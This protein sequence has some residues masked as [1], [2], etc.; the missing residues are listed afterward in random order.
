MEFFTAFKITSS[1]L[2]AQRKKMDVITGNI[3]NASTTST[4]EGGP[5]KRKA[6]SF[7]ADPVEKGFDRELREAVNAVKV[8]QVVEDTD[9]FKKVFDPAH[10]DADADGF[11]TMPNVNLM[12]EM[13][14]L[15]TA[16]RAYEANAS[17]FDAVKSMALKA[18]EIGK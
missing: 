7:A 1:G 8:G 4:P 16:S 6:I 3:A 17:A 9:N 13:T 18:I 15:I 12:L 2:A 11:V 10:P 5:Y 14:E